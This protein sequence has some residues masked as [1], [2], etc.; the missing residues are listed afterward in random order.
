MADLRKEIANHFGNESKPS[1]DSLVLNDGFENLKKERAIKFFSGK[2]WSDV[3]SHLRNLKYEP[4]FGAAYYF[5]EWSVMS[6]KSASYYLR[7]YLEFLSEN[8]YEDNPDEEFI[9]C[10][11]YALYD[12]IYMNK[13]SPFTSEQTILLKKIAE[14]IEKMAKDQN[15][16]EYAGDHI[17]DNTGKFLS[18][19][20]LYE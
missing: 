3:L 6:K 15:R 10:F 2:T 19:L 12:V 9:C 5:E 11:F 8:L 4:I 18:E 16:F 20:K 7:A 1:T 17:L 14:Y 13:D